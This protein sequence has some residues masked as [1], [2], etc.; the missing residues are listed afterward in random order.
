MSNFN[1]NLET[2]L[3]KLENFVSS[4]TVVGEPMVMGNITI[5]PLVD[6][7]FG[8]GL[9]NTEKRVNK[10]G[11]NSGGGGMG[12]KISP[13]SIMVINNGHVQL[14]SVNDK[15]SINKVIDMVPGI[16]N[17]LMPSDND[18]VDVKIEE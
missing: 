8:L 16:V 11:K 10:D 5:V 3:N 14:I 7:S 18:T 12:A 15:N 2:M 4:K 13:N 6:I 9:G 1:E 17:K